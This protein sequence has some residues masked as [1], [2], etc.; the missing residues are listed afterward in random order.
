MLLCRWRCS[1]ELNDGWEILLLLLLLLMWTKN[2][3]WKLCPDPANE[4]RNS[5]FHDVVLLKRWSHGECIVQTVRP[6]LPSSFNCLSLAISHIL[7]IN[8]SDVNFLYLPKNKT[9]MGTMSQAH[10]GL[11]DR[12][13]HFPHQLSER[14]QTKKNY[15]SK[16]CTYLRT[17]R[18]YEYREH[19]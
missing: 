4:A 3:I 18:G 1:S 5:R 19:I 16:V 17:S 10:L 6:R 14:E 8:V 13:I 12:Q 11:R 9:H 7:V 15:V 2:Y